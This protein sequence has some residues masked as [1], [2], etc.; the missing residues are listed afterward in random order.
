M[1]TGNYLISSIKKLIAKLLEI[2]S[3]KLLG[4][5]ARETELATGEITSTS[6]D[7]STNI[8]VALWK[9]RALGQKSVVSSK[10]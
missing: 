3:V 1:R 4:E 9:A 6:T 7:T 10:P 2:N 5:K 8:D